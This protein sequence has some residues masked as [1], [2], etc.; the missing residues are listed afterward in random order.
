MSLA[1][2]SG[3]HGF[4]VLSTQTYDANY[5][6]PGKLFII[7]VFMFFILFYVAAQNIA[8]N[9]LL[10]ANYGGGFQCIPH[11]FGHVAATFAIPNALIL[12]LHST[13]HWNN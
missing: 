5:Y 10:A 3:V 9:F 11:Y 7:F 1:S 2:I 12:P 4:Q 13:V 8:N 6:R